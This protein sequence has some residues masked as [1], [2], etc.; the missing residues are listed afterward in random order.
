MVSAVVKV[1]LLVIVVLRAL[2]ETNQLRFL[3]EMIIVEVLKEE[4]RGVNVLQ[5]KNSIVVLIVPS[6]CGRPRVMLLI[7][8]IKSSS[9]R[10][11]RY[12]YPQANASSTMSCIIRRLSGATETDTG[13]PTTPSKY[14]SATLMLHYPLN[15]CPQVRLLIYQHSTS[16]RLVAWQPQAIAMAHRCR[17]QLRLI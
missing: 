8:K 1:V 14:H 2:L 9:S 17:V 3:H 5:E 11:Q 6:E 7:S 16:G 15:L 10:A 13:C 4:G 12:F